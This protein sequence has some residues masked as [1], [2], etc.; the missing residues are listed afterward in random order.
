MA[1][2]DISPVIMIGID[3]CSLGY[4]KLHGNVV[5]KLLFKFSNHI[6]SFG[7]YLY[8]SLYYIFLLEYMLFR[9]IIVFDV[10]NEFLYGY[11]GFGVELNMCIPLE[12]E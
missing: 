4:N 8:Y 3:L 5:I 10:C 6:I 9:F 2:S 11:Q 12:S 1:A 7:W